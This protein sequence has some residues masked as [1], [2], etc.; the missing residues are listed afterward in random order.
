[1]DVLLNRIVLFVGYTTGWLKKWLQL[2][3]AFVKAPR[4]SNWFIFVVSLLLAAFYNFSFF[5]KV[6]EVYP[7]SAHSILPLASVFIVLTLLIFL[8]LVLV[9]PPKLTKGILVF[10]IT[11]SALISYFSDSF[12]SVMDQTMLLN[13][14]NT[15]LAEVLDLLSPRFFIYMLLFAVL[16]STFL[17]QVPVQQRPFTTET[18]SRVKATALSALVIFSLLL[19]F[20][21]FYAAFFREHK[22][23]RYYANPLFLGYSFTKWLASAYR[24]DNAA[25]AAI[26]AD[27]HIKS[28]DAHRELIVFVLGET[29][30]A[31]HLSL[32]GYHKKTTP[33]LE[34]ENI[35][36][37][38]NMTACG[39][40]TATSVP[41][42]FSI[43]GRDAF[44]HD[45]G[46]H[47]ENLVD[48]L[49]HTGS[50]DVIWRDNNSDSKGVATRI[51]YENFKTPEKNRHCD[52][53]CRD[54]GMLDG[55]QDYI[56]RSQKKDIFI[57][58]HQMGSHGPAYY[59]RYPPAFEKF[60]PACHTGEIE[61]CTTEEISNAYDNT[62]LYTDYFL[63]E[64]IRLLKNNSREFET[65]MF[66]VSD[67]GESLGEG[68]VFLHGLPY[69]FAPREQKEVASVLWIGDSMLHEVNIATLRARHDRHYS[70]DH[71][72]HTLL[73][74]LEVETKVYRES[75]DIVHSP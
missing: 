58:L 40:S 46:E 43:F 55:L 68:G 18:L 15:D 72:F 50:V 1:M 12:G 36:S 71:V 66:Y 41:C 67:H 10:V 45:K 20:G 6:L 17:I 56:N 57:V 8:V 53:E 33:L 73:G 38:S 74:L 47:T 42:M 23:L 65:A 7:P 52:V 59:K 35:I 64:V 49:A 2:L 9:T 13:V 31:D 5:Q 34:R 11:L 25:V 3:R 26:G 69:A 37:F 63:S 70:H 29:V 22:T 48:V 21:K 51:T 75:M 27:A 28:D 44:T 24:P 39:T 62:I 32:N 4:T 60:K 16:P 19:S 54:I 30:R 61:E 14:L